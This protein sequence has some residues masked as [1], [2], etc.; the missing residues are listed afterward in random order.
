MA[1]RTVRV[2]LQAVVG[3]YQKSMRQAANDTK[4]LG[5]R[6]E[7]VGKTLTK[8]LT[9]AAGAAALAFRKAAGD[10]NRGT[11]EII[12]GTGATG[13]ALDDLQGS[14]RRVATQVPQDFGQVGTV[15]AELNTRL[16]VTGPEL[17]EVSKRVLDF[18]RVSN[19]DGG[20]AAADLGR[21]MNALEIDVGDAASV[22]DKLI[23]ASQESGIQVDRLTG[24]IVEAGPAFEEMGFDLDRTI[25]LFSEFERAGARPEELLGSLNI[26][27]TRLA[28]EGFTDAEEAFGEL[29]RR[30]QDAPDL[31]SAVDI[32]ADAF[33]ARVGGKVAEDIRAGRFE[34]DDFVASLQGAEGRLEDTADAMLTM[35][36]RLA[37][38]RDRA[39][40][41]VGPVGEVGFAI[42]SIAAGAGPA[43]LG[44]SKL[45]SALGGLRGSALLAK[46][47]L[48]PFG[49]AVGGTALLVWEVKRAWDAGAESA[50]ELADE[51][52]ASSGSV[53]EANERMAASLDEHIEQTEAGRR[54]WTRLLDSALGP[55]AIAY[56]GVSM[57][58]GNLIGVETHQTGVVGR[59][60][61]DANA[62]A[63]GYTLWR[64]SID[65][66]GGSLFDLS[67][68][69]VTGTGPALAGMNTQTSEL[70]DALAEIDP[71]LAAVAGGLADLGDGADDTAGALD[72]LTDAQKAVAAS[73]APLACY[74]LEVAS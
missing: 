52:R 26:V 33:G 48:V 13:D 28:R 2:R 64:E 42:A 8:T 72:G 20:R 60:L 45:G 38:L 47:A 39:I 21:L 54:S 61:D 40:G 36:D 44:V 51:I 43:L 31:L 68:Q 30:I 37:M 65:D 59:M 55:A 53:E 27:L 3:D 32:A 66:T 56:D 16:G 73:I 9:P 35:D 74:P 49:L 11:N 5:E 4:G 63:H 69:I 22:M 41:V 29:L 58:L 25:A 17:E 57:A 50:R 7:G 19:Q 14:M 10:W 70:V 15:I 24:F 1:D 23:F 34:V 46:G 12:A 18:A 67:G 71:E 6:V 62:A